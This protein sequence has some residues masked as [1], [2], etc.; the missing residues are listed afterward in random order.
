M[1]KKIAK[2]HAAR[3]LGRQVA[4]FWLIEVQSAA[5]AIETNARDLLQLKGGPRIVNG[6]ATFET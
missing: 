3:S 5:S 2:A 1:H 6:G 4:F